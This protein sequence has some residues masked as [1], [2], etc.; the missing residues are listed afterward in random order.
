MFGQTKR[1]IVMGLSPLF[2]QSGWKAVWT[3][4]SSALLEWRHKL[5]Q[6]CLADREDESRQLGA[7]GILIDLQSW[8]VVKTERWERSCRDNTS[9]PVYIPYYDAVLQSVRDNTVF[10]A[11]VLLTSLTKP[12]WC[13]AVT[14]TSTGC[15]SSCSNGQALTPFHVNEE[16]PATDKKQWM[17]FKRRKK[18]HSKNSTSPQKERLIICNNGTPVA[19]RE[20]ITGK[21]RSEISF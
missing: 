3:A 6:H 18:R 5:I 12:P 20:K 19:L 4:D 11:R 14:H 16:S 9:R 17:A 2:Q 10:A 15:L 7:S 8:L 1:Y 13:Q 21:S